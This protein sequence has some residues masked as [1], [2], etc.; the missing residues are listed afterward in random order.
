MN[1]WRL[2]KLRAMLL[3]LVATASTP[4]RAAECSGCLQDG[5]RTVPVAVSSAPFP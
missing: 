4:A 3:F 1:I 5:S 2:I